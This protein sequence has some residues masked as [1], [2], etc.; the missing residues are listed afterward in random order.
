MLY[1]TESLIYYKDIIQS[2]TIALMMTRH[3]I[4][5]I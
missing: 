3:A 4:H 1:I 5:E 2:T